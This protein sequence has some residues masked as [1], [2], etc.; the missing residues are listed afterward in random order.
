MQK[1]KTIEQNILSIFSEYPGLKSIRHKKMLVWHYWR[2]FDSLGENMTFETFK[3]LTDEESILRSRRKILESIRGHEVEA[4]QRQFLH[5][6]Y[7]QQKK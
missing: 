5:R 6:N 2:T 1:L 4:L 7:Y 3:E